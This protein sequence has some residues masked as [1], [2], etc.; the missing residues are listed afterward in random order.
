MCTEQR[1]GCLIERAADMFIASPEVPW[2]RQ[3]CERIG[4]ADSL[5]STRPEKRGGLVVFRGRLVPL[6]EGFQLMTPT[7]LWPIVTTPL[8]SPLGKLRLAWERFVPARGDGK[9]ESL[10]EFATRRF[11]RQAYERIIQPLVGG[12]YT[13]D[14][15][16]L[17][18]AAALPQI[19]QMEREY[20]SLIRAAAKRAKTNR[21]DDAQGARYGLFFAPPLG[22]SQL[23]DALAER[24]SP[25][26][27]KFHSPVRSMRRD[28]E[29]HWRLEVG[30]KDNVLTADAV[31]VALPAGQAGR[32]LHDVDAELAQRI[33]SIPCAGVSIV[34][35]A[36]LREDLPRI[37][38]R[39]FGCIVPIAERRNIL[40]VSFASEKFPGRAPK[41]IVLLRTFVGGAIQ[42]ELADLDDSRLEQLVAE[43]LAELL[44]AAQP[45]QFSFVVRWTG[46]MPQYH[47]GHSD[48]VEKIELRIE[49][50]AGLEV[51]GSAYHGV[52]IPH[53]I[54]G[55]EEAAQR[56]VAQVTL[57]KIKA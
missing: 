45:P 39:G 26:S 33:G 54:H 7:R 38:A 35:S 5:L 13:A 42:P 1:D 10:A 24:I 6:P 57:M 20:G 31:I 43:E 9:E 32:L 11:G 8:L 40:A 37:P 36:Y 14:P 46:A 49:S 19:V 47:I 34:I 44:G 3:L 51:A 53:C 25:D 41:E 15:K 50:I 27:V 29:G 21:Q 55:A 2:A 22:M 12:I 18:V 56:I 16:R 23:V 48:L 4:L 28:A 52:G 17:S 30:D